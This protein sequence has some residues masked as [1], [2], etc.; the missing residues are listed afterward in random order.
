[1]I[2][3]GLFQEGPTSS[4]STSISKFQN[5]EFEKVESSYHI[6]KSVQDNNSHN[7]TSRSTDFSFVDGTSQTSSSVCLASVLSYAMAS[8]PGQDSVEDKLDKMM[9]FLQIMQVKQEETVFRSEEKLWKYI[10]AVATDHD[11]FKVEVQ[12]EIKSL[13]LL[14]GQSSLLHHNGTPID[15][16]HSSSFSTNSYSSNIPAIPSST[17]RYGPP[18]PNN[19]ASGLNISSSDS[20]ANLMLMMTEAF[21]KL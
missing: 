19:A 9:V 10:R 20:Q 15:Q 16:T 14:L 1:L 13:R 6:S 8:S 7:S 21:S 5:S 12:S 17:I 4:V 3:H 18:I 11:A 2:S